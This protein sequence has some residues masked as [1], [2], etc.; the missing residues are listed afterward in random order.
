MKKHLFNAFKLILIMHILIS[1]GAA[2]YGQITGSQIDP[3]K[4]ILKF[5][6]PNTRDDPVK[7]VELSAWQKIKSTVYGA[8][9]GKICDK[10][11]AYAAVSSDYTIVGDLRDLVTQSWKFLNN[12]EVDGIVFTLS[13]YG[14][15][16]STVPVIPMKTIYL[17]GFFIKNPTVILGLSKS[18]LVVHTLK[19]LKKHNLVGL[20][21]PVLG[22]FLLVSL[23]PPYVTAAVF[24]SSALYLMIILIQICKIKGESQLC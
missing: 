1:S 21:I 11:S 4:A 22:L 9:T 13:A 5:Q 12:E 24:V 20:M 15:V 3:I 23:L 8:V 10:Y 16:L 17:K 2:L 6:L 19:I 18:H 14:L 7:D